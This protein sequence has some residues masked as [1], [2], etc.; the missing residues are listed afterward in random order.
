[1]NNNLKY[2]CIPQNFVHS[3]LEH[4]KILF[5]T[6]LNA[7][8]KMP[9][10]FEPYT[11][12]RLETIPPRSNSTSLSRS[13]LNPPNN[14]SNYILGKPL[15]TANHSRLILLARLLLNPPVT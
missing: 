5:P 10:L 7:I 13:E 8:A 3:V 1:M 4:I 14:L 2:I 12:K 11:A 6:C 9:T 15:G